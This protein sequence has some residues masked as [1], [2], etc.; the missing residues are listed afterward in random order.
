MIR[1]RS[2]QNIDCAC[3]SVD[4]LCLAKDLRPTEIDELNL[5]ITNFKSVAK[6]E[7]AFYAEDT[8]QYLHAVY[9]GCCKDYLLDENGIEH[10]DN[11]YLPGDIIGL[12]S[13]P[14]RK[15]CFS[16]VALEDT[17]LCLIPIDGLLSLM[18]NYDSILKRVMNITSYKM[19]NDQNISITT[20]A[21]QRVIDFILNIV[22]RLAERNKNFDT[23][24]LPMS[25]I[26]ISHFLGMA[27]ETVNRIL[28]KFHQEKMINIINKKLFI[29]DLDALK[30]LANSNNG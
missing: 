9:S 1:K 12:E 28:K 8:M 21:N 17:Q 22:N 29:L 15:H 7:H 26:D 16:L 13:I 11:F 24:P 18:Q 4:Y 19:Q 30:A 27:H 5:L 6:N 14:K 23:L 25:Q 20:N 2:S 3:C 10:I